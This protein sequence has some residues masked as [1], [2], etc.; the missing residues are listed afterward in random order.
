MICTTNKAPVRPTL[1]FVLAALAT[2]AMAAQLSAGERV[3][4]QLVSGRQFD[5]E[6]SPRTNE[7]RLWL[8]FRSRSAELLRP[9]VWE[10]IENAQFGGESF[11]G[12]ALRD[13]LLSTPIALQDYEAE[14][15]S[16]A[17]WVEES[18]APTAERKG[19]IADQVLETLFSSSPVPAPIAVPPVATV[20]FDAYLANWDRDVE[21]DGL[22]VH[23]VPLDAYGHV[24]PA[25]GNLQ[26]ELFAARRIAFNDGPHKRGRRVGAIGRWTEQFLPHC[27]QTDGAWF[28]LPFQAEHPEFNMNLGAHGLVH[29]RL[30]VPGAGV[31]ED[32]ID[33]V[34]IRPF[35]P[36]RDSLQ[37][38]EGRR[39]LATEMTGRGKRAN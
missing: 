2:V 37:Q 27:I 34:R 31:F 36:L 15:Q 28:K 29:V 30:V 10:R 1:L 8:S 24:V 7:Q 35:A 20:R 26:V 14:F 23:A 38:V 3:V 11:S 6:V 16:P 17:P 39:F 21:V 13:H 19:E 33:G 32:S 9:V 18:P 22:I 4:V 5:A 25:R 12:E